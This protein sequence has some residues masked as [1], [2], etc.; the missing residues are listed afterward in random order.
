MILQQKASVLILKLQFFSVDEGRDSC[1]SDS[2]QAESDR[3]VHCLGRVFHI[4]TP[5]TRLLRSLPVHQL[6]TDYD[7][8]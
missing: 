7:D 1:S 5:T 8:Y 3:L 6:F 2:V 4:E